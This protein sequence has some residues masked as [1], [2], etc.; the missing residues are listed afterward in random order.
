M[1]TDHTRCKTSA[2]LAPPHHCQSQNFH[3]C[4][5]PNNHWAMPLFECPEKE[6]EVEL[7]ATAP[8]T[9]I[10]EC[11]QRPGD[12]TSS[13]NEMKTVHVQTPSVVFVPSL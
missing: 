5:Y 8:F 10:G 12:N 11:P 3:P 1:Q 7:E 4:V 2:F 13:C 6:K 9:L